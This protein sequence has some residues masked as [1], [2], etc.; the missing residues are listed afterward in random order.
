MADLRTVRGKDIIFAENKRFRR[1]VVRNVFEPETAADFWKQM[2]AAYGLED[3]QQMYLEF[4]K[5]FGH[6]LHQH[7]ARSTVKLVG[8]FAQTEFLLREHEVQPSLCKAVNEAR[9]R[10][11]K[12]GSGELTI[13]ILR[14]NAPYDFKA[15]CLFIEQ[16]EETSVPPEVER[17]FPANRPQRTLKVPEAEYLR[18]LVSK[19]DNNNIYGQIE[20]EPLEVVICYSHG[21]S[22]YNFDWTYLRQQLHGGSQINIIRPRLYDGILYP[23]LIIVEPDYLVDISAIAACF[24]NYAHSPLIYLLNKIRATEPT[25]AIL[26][27]NLAGQLLDEEVHSEGDGQP[28]AESVQQFFKGN[29]LNLLAANVSPEF[30]ENAIKQKHNIH[31]AIKNDMPQQ[32][33]EYQQRNVMLEPSFFSEMLGLQ[34]RMDFLQLDQ[35]VLIEQ[36]SG[37]GGWPQPDP[38]TPVHQEKHY[39]QMLLYMAL[40]RYN[41]REQYDRNDHHL[42]AFLLYSRYPNSLLGM[43]FAPQLLFEALKIRNGIACNELHFAEG[44][45][46][47]LDTLTPERLNERKAHGTLWERY[48]RPQIEA[49]LRPIHN[50]SPLERMY[51]F[52]FLTFIANEHVLSKFGNRTKENS[53][54]ASAW[55]ASL[56][57]KRQAGNIY[58]RL[59]LLSP[60]VNDSPRPV[61]RLVLGFSEQAD[62]DMS[63]FRLNDVVV[64]YPY[65][66]GQEPDLRRT[67][68]FRC[69][70]EQV[71]ANRITLVLRAPQT[72][73]NVFLRDADKHW[74]IEHD[75]IE[76]SYSSLYR[77]M[78]AFLSAPQ[79]RRDLL[80]LQRDP[81]VDSSLQLCGDYGKFNELALRVK[82]AQDFFLII[83]PPGTGKTSFGLMTTLHEALLTPDASI[84]LLSYTNRAVD[85]ICS[86]LVEEKL[87]FIRIGNE[88]S[89]PEVYRP[90]LL[91]SAVSECSRLAQVKERIMS[92]RIFVGTTTALNTSMSLFRLKSF[93]L[94]IV[95]EASQI[96]EPH[97]M[98]LLSAVKD[99]APAI[100]K[101]VFIGDHKQLPAVVQQHS[102]ESRVHEAA[103]N[104]I[105]LTDCRLSLFERLLKR[106]RERP[107]VVFMLKRQGRMHHDIAD[108][109]NRAF[110]AGQLTEVPLEHQQQPL[111]EAAP[112][113]DFFKKILTTQRIAFIA[114]PQ[115]PKS[116]SDKVNQ[117]EAD[118]IA[119]AVVKIYELTGSNFDVA[120]T[121][122]II[123]PYRNQIAT[124]RNTLD[125]YGIPAL[126][127][128][129]IDTVERYQGS[130]RDYILYGFTIQQYYQLNF[131]T[132]T[133]FEE[134]GALIDRKLNVAM[135]RA[136][137]HLLLFGNPDL[138]S[139]VPTFKELLEYT[140]AR[141]AY[142]KPSADLSDYKNIYSI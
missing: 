17:L 80:L 46:E 71:T 137:E 3:A 64:L 112:H 81:A 92:G 88:L 72:D 18:V 1:M 122:G 139:A 102:D 28:Y 108:F 134:D 11:R 91:S 130:Q 132:D 128:I 19:V 51:Y 14:E 126:H 82:Q 142:F 48:Q 7:S 30:H 69:S 114:A 62:N 21:N 27:G 53:G 93:D 24:E 99:N 86:K 59:Q 101:F 45:F 32:L 23:E 120:H 6:F 16:V 10:F 66:P 70:I 118:L 115:P 119:E 65:T 125:R 39:V 20:A 35:K 8:A 124:I 44:G 12:A 96:L 89:C 138:L 9:I 36:K 74:A 131:L 57:E 117:T 33:K 22:V 60:S 15:I 106:Y 26:L 95:D 58:D 136:R 109:P 43:S 116:P 78:H 5:I 110:Y 52:R 104:D 42:S 140:Q 47:L 113:A 79:E 67:M 61:T 83:G 55:H 127:D 129:T 75:F 29:A 77:G 56:N 103:L 38:N 133:V 105:L 85:E 68:V 49:L 2:V 25:E 40:L 121:V 123:V 73:A 31:K 54:F 4:G 98:G 141:G 50:A 84:L 94:A 87:D 13:D 63:N 34:G 76:S 41:Y 97:L 90:Y 107:E 100:R 37:K 135:T 111:P